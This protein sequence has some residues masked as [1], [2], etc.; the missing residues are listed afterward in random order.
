MTKVGRLQ[1]LAKGMI[2]QLALPTTAAPPLPTTIS[3]LTL[4]SC[5]TMS[6]ATSL[7]TIFKEKKALRSRVRKELRSMDPKI[8]SLEGINLVQT[9][10][11]C[12]YSWIIPFKFV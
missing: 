4:R 6:T 9:K 12:V 1:R 3:G 2:Q 7:D 8:R 11:Q 5:T 10:N